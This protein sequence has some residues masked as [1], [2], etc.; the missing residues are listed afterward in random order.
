MSKKIQISPSLMCMDLTDFKYQ[1]E[2]LGEKSDCFH[3]DIMDGHYVP[4]LTLSPFFMDAVRKVSKLD[5]EAHL[6]VTNPQDYIIPMV[7]AGAAMISLH[8]EVIN[9][10]AF[11]LFDQIKKLGCKTGAV[12][13]PETPIDILQYYIHKLDKITVMTVDPGFAGQSFIEETLPKIAQLQA[14]KQEHKLNYIIEID[15]SCN[16]GTFQRLID[17]G[18]E[19][20][21]VGSSGLFSMA[22][23]LPEAW[24]IMR[25][26][27][28][29]CGG[30]IK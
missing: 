12:L 25:A 9:G 4:N 11:R 24:E 8:A 7:D 21:V 16:K 13:N 5:M 3:I 23:N 27:I 20:L 2:F 1:I 26:H 15:G 28:A 17:A 30:E 29:A 6:M 10:Q 22:D 14:Y 19:S 18:A